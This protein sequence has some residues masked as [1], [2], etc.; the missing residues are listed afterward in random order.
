MHLLKGLQIQFTKF[1]AY[2]SLIG[3]PI[4]IVGALLAIR[5]TEYFFIAIIAAAITALFLAYFEQTFLF[6]LIV[7]SG[8]DIFS[9][10]GIPALFAIGLD[11]LVLSYLLVLYLTKQKIYL[12]KFFFVFLTWVLLQGLWPILTALGALDLGS[13]YLAESVREWVRVST[14]LI[15]YLGVSQLKEMHPQN[16][17]NSLLLSLVIPLS[18]AALQLIL[19]SSMLPGFLQGVSGSVFEAGSRINGT[20]GHPNTFASFLVLFIGLT[21]WKI[22]EGDKTL[23]WSLIL[24]AEVFFLVSTKALVGPPMLAILLLTLTASKLNFK[25]TVG[26]IFIMFMLLFLFGSSD[27]GK[28]RLAS[29]L[30]TPLLNSDLTINRAILMSS[31][32]GNSFN[33]RLSQWNF[34]VEEWKRSP[35]FGYG[36]GLVSH[37]GPVRAYAHNDYV[38]VL[39]EGGIVGVL[40][41]VVFLL[42]QA[43]SLMKTRLT[44]SVL[45][46]KNLCMSLL[47]VFA[48]SLTGM[49]TENIWS[50]TTFFFYWWTLFNVSS[51]D[52]GK[53]EEKETDYAI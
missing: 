11:A 34:L 29:V 31:Y 38:R 44:S 3:I 18:A 40:V 20:L 43:T 25:N 14:W 24:A 33:W 35:V 30:E 49:T 39:A 2:L 41:F 37:I 47:A 6:L 9:G 17:V 12:D 21:Y 16:I 5:K 15:V 22:K 4:G 13:N 36:L 53:P 27:F 1:L 26:A 23:L 52:W 8:L 10:Q 32:D 45:S 46:Q 50:H 51:W 48:A 42:S 28:E 19:P 7:R